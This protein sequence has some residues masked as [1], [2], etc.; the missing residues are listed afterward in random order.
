M[1]PHLQGPPVTFADVLP[2]ARLRSVSATHVVLDGR[3][4]LR[5]EL[6][7]DIS[8]DGIPDRDYVDM[9]TLVELPI[10]FL[11]GMIE[12]DLLARL[13]GHWPEGARG[14]AGLAFHVQQEENSFECVYLR[15]TNGT[16]AHAPSPRNERAIQYF[17]YPDWRFERLRTERPGAYEA[18]APIDIDEWITLRLDVAGDE[19]RALVNGEECLS[20]APT[21]LHSEGGRIGLFVDIGTVAYFSD[22]RVQP[23]PRSADARQ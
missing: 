9:P 20:V 14:F 8:R 4:A 5:V 12:V 23:R 10:E 1:T 22:L 16:R 15:P 21:L 2:R 19:V 3:A 17:A 18:G 6:L 11:D 13:N 7:E